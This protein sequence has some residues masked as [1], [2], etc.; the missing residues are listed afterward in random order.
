MIGY[1]DAAE[2]E[3]RMA[4]LESRYGEDS[5]DAAR[6]LGRA[7]IASAIPALA[8]ALC[9]DAAWESTDSACMKA[10]AIATIGG[11]DAIA[12]LVGLLVKYDLAAEE[13]ANGDVSD[14]YW[15]VHHACV[16][17]LVRIGT[18]AIPALRPLLQHTNRSAAQSA[19]E[20]LEKLGAGDFRP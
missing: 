17:G 5:N 3:R 14:E 18:L 15:R 16:H 2:L 11:E 4:A 8:S 10:E 20:A 13:D 7:A 1:V 12:T 9:R 19:A 6:A